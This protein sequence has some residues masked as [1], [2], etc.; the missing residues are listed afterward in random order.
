MSGKL[1]VWMPLYIGDY[2]KDT[3]RLTTL[4]HGA[5]LLLLMDYWTSGGPLPD[6]DEQLAAI[7][8]LPVR[9]WK[10]LRASLARFFVIADGLWTQKRA[11]EEIA[12]KHEISTGRSEVGKAGAAKRWGKGNGKRIAIAIPEPMAKPSQTDGQ[13]QSQEEPNNKKSA[14]V[15]LKFSPE[16]E[17]VVQALDDAL[18]AGYGTERIRHFRDPNDHYFA[19]QMIDTGAP[20]DLICD[21]IK[22]Q[23]AEWASEGQAPAKRVETFEKFVDTAYRRRLKAIAK[24][25]SAP[26]AAPA[27]TVSAADRETDRWKAKVANF[28]KDGWWS[29]DNG[30]APGEPGC[31]VP[32]H[33]LIEAAN[34]SSAA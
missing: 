26:D 15:N 13:S 18:L 17:A 20:L 30:P 31:K 14:G 25:T 32:P 21:T 19:Q 4:G 9:D 23:V 27:V 5:Y 11:D 12:K 10:K 28:R 33:L 2:L 29:P 22:G 7:T 34:T 3:S 8:R 24:R 16:S 6:D 1:D